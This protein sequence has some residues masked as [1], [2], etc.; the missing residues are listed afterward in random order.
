MAT[1]RDVQIVAEDTAET[2]LV[3]AQAAE[4]ALCVELLDHYQA[5]ETA[6]RWLQHT[7]GGVGA[8]DEQIAAAV[9]SDLGDL[10]ATVRLMFVVG[11]PGDDT[12]VAL[13][14]SVAAAE[15]AAHSIVGQL[16]HA[17]RVDL[18]SAA[19]ALAAADPLLLKSRA[20]IAERR[21]V[22]NLTIAYRAVTLVARAVREQSWGEAFLVAYPHLSWTAP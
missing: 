12:V 3:K 16:E 5:V 14:E 11:D 21:S 2:A 7:A 9:G 19:T 8:S 13:P 17:V 22:R 18:P 10:V 20:V 15:V 4:R 6:A 1:R